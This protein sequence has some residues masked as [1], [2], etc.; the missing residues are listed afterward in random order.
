M[1]IMSSNVFILMGVSATG[2][3]TLGNALAEVSG[4]S[5]YDGDD[6]HPEANRL[7][8]SSGKALTDSDRM[9]WLE[10]LAELIKEKSL[11]E[12]PVFIACSALKSSYRDIL[13]SAS[14]SL[15]FLHLHTDA[16]LLR[17][18]IT[19]RFE[20]GEH[21][22]HPSLL[23]SQLE[24]LELPSNALF[25]DVSHSLEEV[26]ELVLKNHPHLRSR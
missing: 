26:V 20:S 17:Q 13:R 24:T 15:V 2:K 3:T 11:G 5:F 18:R 7:K 10:I 14:D 1:K 9:P 16:E 19:E 23:D 25:C 4:G 22:M 6:Y 8:M 12:T 21:F